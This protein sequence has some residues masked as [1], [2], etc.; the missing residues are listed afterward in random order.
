MAFLQ[1]VGDFFTGKST[2]VVEPTTT[3]TTTA[4]PNTGWY[5]F[6]GVVLVLG[7]GWLIFGKNSPF[8]S[9]AGTGSLKAA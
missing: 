4:N 3:T 9:G 1:D 2:T 5:I 8:R 6:G 7:L